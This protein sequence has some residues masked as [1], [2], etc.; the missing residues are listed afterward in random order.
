[1]MPLRREL[2]IWDSACTLCTFLLFTSFCCRFRAY[3]EA[4]LSLGAM[5]MLVSNGPFAE[6]V[7]MRIEAVIARNGLYVDGGEITFDQNGTAAP[8]IALLLTPK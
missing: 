8:G 4:K 5:F 6:A 1:M 2:L 3:V 7:L